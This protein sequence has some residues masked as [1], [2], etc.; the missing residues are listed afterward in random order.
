MKG[1]VKSTPLEPVARKIHAFVEGAF[2]R[3][4]CYPQVRDRLSARRGLEIGGPSHIFDT[5]LPCTATSNPWIIAF[6][7]KRHTGRVRDLQE[8]HFTLT[9]G[10]E[11][12]TTS[13]LRAPR[14]PASA[15]LSTT[16]SLIAQS[17]AHRQPDQSPAEL[18]EG[19]E[20]A[21]FSSAGTA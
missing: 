4:R 14:S 7:P 11:P 17:G 8:R 21:W 9:R 20:A 15:T 2:F 16:C 3:A 12:A 1:L 10:R 6:S 18:E 5:N 13:S 19:P